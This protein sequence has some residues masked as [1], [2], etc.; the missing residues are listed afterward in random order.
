MLLSAS[1]I[2]QTLADAL[3][4]GMQSAFI[5]DKDGRLVSYYGG[6]LSEIKVLSALLDNAWFAYM[7]HGTPNVTTNR[8]SLNSLIINNEEGNV[9]VVRVGTFL[10][11]ILANVEVELGILNNRA[12]SLAYNLQDALN[13]EAN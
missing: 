13:V 7:K 11:G 3:E 8:K 9:C 12:N 2:R 4:D 6:E 10:V 5:S 1:G